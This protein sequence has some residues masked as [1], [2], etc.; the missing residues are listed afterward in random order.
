MTSSDNPPTDRLAKTIYIKKVIGKGKN[1]KPKY[2]VIET[3][4]WANNYSVNQRLNWHMARIA[5]S[6]GAVGYEFEVFD[7]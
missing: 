6:L 5:E 2:Q 1:G 4:V 7:D 3:T